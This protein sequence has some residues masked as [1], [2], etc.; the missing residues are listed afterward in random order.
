MVDPL[1][2]MRNPDVHAETVDLTAPLSKRDDPDDHAVHHEG[3]AGISVTRVPSP[4]QRPRAQFL[5]RRERPAPDG[6]AHLVGLQGEVD[7]VQNGG[8]I[9]VRTVHGAPPR[10]TT[11]FPDQIRVVGGRRE[12]NG[13]CEEAVEVERVISGDEGEG[14]VVVVRGEIESLTEHDSVQDADLVCI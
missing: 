12:G 1:H 14:E 3:G 13:G 9:Q 7:L 8:K 6:F 2:V 10:D 4:G 11:E 5:S